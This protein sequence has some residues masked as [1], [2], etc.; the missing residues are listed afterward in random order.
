MLSDK[1]GVRLIFLSTASCF[2]LK[3]LK[4]E[5]YLVKFAVQEKSGKQAAS[6]DIEVGKIQI[7]SELMSASICVDD[8]TTDNPGG[9][10]YSKTGNFLYLCI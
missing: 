9:Y 4:Q 8:E 6:W 1:I 10:K 2:L 7:F 3:N 5:P